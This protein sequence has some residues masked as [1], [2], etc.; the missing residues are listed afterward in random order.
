MADRIFI[1]NLR[2]KCRIGATD[3]ERRE[4][5]D[6]I[7]DV[8]LFRNL[9]RAAITNSLDD[10]VNYKEVMDR[11]SDYVSEGE[12]RLLESLAEGIATRTLNWFRADRVSV[13]ARK[14]KYSNEPSIG[15]EIERATERGGQSWS[16]Q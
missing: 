4:P 8:N 2:L 12:F 11:I 15:V 14:A 7:L 1:E 16:K 13:R 3:D 6:V 10:T 9:E 5:Q